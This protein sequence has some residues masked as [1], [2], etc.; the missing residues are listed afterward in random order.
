MV[1]NC[2][3]E[4]QTLSQSVSEGGVMIFLTDGNHD[5][6]GEDDDNLDDEELQQEIVAS[7]VRIITIAFG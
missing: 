4:W 5:C 7:G 3:F 6:K 1:R 2:S